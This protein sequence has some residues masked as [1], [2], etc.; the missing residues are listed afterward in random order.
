MRIHCI[1][2]NRF[3]KGILL[4]R[5]SCSEVIVPV[6]TLLDNLLVIGAV[7]EQSDLS[8]LLTLLEPQMFA[9]RGSTCYWM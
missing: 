8:K 5:V 3:Y 1:L 9:P 7:Q 4:P 6:L 2:T